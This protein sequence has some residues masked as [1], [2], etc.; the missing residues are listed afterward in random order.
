MQMPGARLSYPGAVLVLAVLAAPALRG[1]DTALPGESA[2]AHYLG[3][4]TSWW[5]THCQ[6]GELYQQDPGFGGSGWGGTFFY[7]PNLAEEFR[8][9]SQQSEHYLECNR[10]TRGGPPAVPVFLELFRY[11]KVSV[12]QAAIYGL[13][14]VALTDHSPVAISALNSAM[15]DDDYTICEFACAA[16][17]QIDP[18]GSLKAGV[19]INSWAASNYWWANMQSRYGHLA[20]RNRTPMRAMVLLEVVVLVGVAGY[21]LWRGKSRLRRQSPSKSVVTSPDSVVL[22]QSNSV[23]LPSATNAGGFTES[24]QP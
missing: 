9:K 3:R 23:T 6:E 15:H 21:L 19:P 14:Q 12:R 1:Q 10:L 22:D 13:A 20:A 17:W 18:D 4:P 5:A 16:L 8:D 24:A 11:E 2:E 7:S